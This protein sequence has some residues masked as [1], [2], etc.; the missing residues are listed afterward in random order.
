M[1]G[2]RDYHTKCSKSH[3]EGQI[4]YGIT[5]MWNLKK[6][7]TRIS[8]MVQQLKLC[9]STTGGADSMP[10]WGPKIPHAVECGQT[11]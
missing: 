11:N 10:G 7:D 8:L 6:K 4:S 1:D 2:P 3:R 9:T 5:Y